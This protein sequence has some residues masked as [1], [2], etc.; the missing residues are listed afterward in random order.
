VARAALTVPYVATSLSE[1]DLDEVVE[2][3]R[4]CAARISERI[5][6]VGAIG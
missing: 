4:D 2:A 5:V 3:A 1:H 6:G